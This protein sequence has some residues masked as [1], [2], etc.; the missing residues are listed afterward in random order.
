MEGEPAES[1]LADVTEA[2]DS[3]KSAHHVRA[4]ALTTDRHVFAE[5]AQV[6]EGTNQQTTFITD[7][8]VLKDRYCFF[9]ATLPLE[10]HASMSR[11]QGE[12]HHPHRQ[13][14]D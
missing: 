1:G 13:C 3:A 10:P 9:F 5:N 14:R 12:A 6:T 2:L 7:C 11:A 4:W 8:R